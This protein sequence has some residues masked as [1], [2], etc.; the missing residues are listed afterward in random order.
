MRA[1]SLNLR[2]R[3]VTVVGL[4]VEGTALVPYLVAQ[5]AQVTVSD[6]RLSPALAENLQKIHGLPVNLALG[7]NRPEDCVDADILFI[8]QGVP[9]DLPALEAAK[10]GGVPFSSVT[11]LFMELCPA[12]IVGVTGSA[13]K[14]TTTSLVGEMFKAA[15]R[16]TLVGGNLGTMLLDRLDE[17]TSEHWVV[18]EISHTQ[19][20][21]TDQSPHVAAITNIS[22]S[23]ADRYPSLDQYIDLKKRLYH[24][25]GP[26][27]WLVL[28][29]DD[30]VTRAMAHQ[31][32][33]RVLWFS[34]HPDSSQDGAFIEAGNIMLRL[35]GHESTVLPVSGIKLL[36]VHNQANV[37]AA[38]AVSG[39]AGLPV[40]AM[41]QAAHTFTGVP[42]RLEWVRE[43]DG[44]DYNDDSIGTTPERVIAGLHSFDRPIVLLAGGREKH[45]ALGHWAS[46]VSKRCTGVV[47]FGEAGPLLESAL[48]PVWLDRSRSIRVSTLEEA[49]PAARGLARTGDIVLLSPACTSFDAYP[50]FEKRG[51]HFKQLVNAL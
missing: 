12:P 1:H 25:Q 20:E 39:A 18:L 31:A 3:R 2:N 51:E 48:Q 16:K 5:G 49:V 34:L 47:F 33:A 9:L 10:A 7:G 45:L 29:A 37:V 19:L 26:Y 43:I 38:C 46:E 13:G 27:D 24:Y 6:A 35:N 15:G 11:K 36:G 21:L 32:R 28:N 41:A 8:S 4:G 42:H 17:L 50:N 23:H 40:E 30:A 14:S 44:V 22:P